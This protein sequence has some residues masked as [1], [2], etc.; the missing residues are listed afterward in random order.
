MKLEPMS[1]EEGVNRYFDDRNELSAKTK[2]NYRYQLKEFTKWCDKRNITNLNELTGKKIQ[3][4]KR[5]RMDLV[6]PATVKNNMW[7]VKTFMQFCEHINAVPEG[8]HRKVRIPTLNYE[9]EVKDDKLTQKEAKLIK[10]HLEKY[11][12]ATVRHVIFTILWST[13]VRSGTLHGLDRGDFNP[14]KGTLAIRHRPETDTP[15]KNKERA[16][17]KI[18]ISD[19][20]I[21][22]IKDYLT[23]THSGGTDE[24]GRVPLIMGRGTRPSK[25]TIQRNIYTVT[26]PCHYMNLCPHD[27]D[28]Q[29]CEA[30]SYS[31]ASK[32]P[33]SV[34]PHALRK[35]YVTASLNA[36]QPKDVTAERVNMSREV[37]DKHYDKRTEDEKMEQRRQHL[38]E[39]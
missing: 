29:T 19:D 20:T 38:K 16:E 8:V 27:R 9:D 11:E 31:T 35:G 17:R 32:C 25:A 21:E 30:T 15:L 33:S 24:Y 34:G 23:Y 26:R 10:A 37:L 39:I 6:K 36:E 22:V 14:T 13:G 12:Y 18:A 3:E 7:T 5:W 2:Q 28:P 4:F 1:P